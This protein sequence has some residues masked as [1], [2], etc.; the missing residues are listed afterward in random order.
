MSYQLKEASYPL[1][2]LQNSSKEEI[3][4][5]VRKAT[6][7]DQDRL[8]DLV[9]Q[10]QLHVEASN[11]HLWQLTQR[12]QQKLVH[13]VADMLSDKHGLAL[14]AEHK[15]HI[16]GFAYGQILQRTDYAY[17]E[18]EQV[19]HISLRYVVGN[20]GAEAFWSQLGFTPI[21]YIA[22]ADRETLQKHL[23]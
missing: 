7:E 1:M 16:V 10:L 18:A 14:V 20:T 4:M 17:F 23:K 22:Y 21:I 19:R 3:N 12:G 8:L 15:S 11:P 13:D 5:R 6:T 9:L 2:C